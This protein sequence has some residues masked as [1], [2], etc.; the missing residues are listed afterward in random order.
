MT[1]KLAPVTDALVAR[2]EAAFPNISTVVGDRPQDLYPAHVVHQVDG[3]S[4]FFR[5]LDSTHGDGT[6][7]WQVTCVALNAAH[8][9]GMRDDVVAAL[10]TEPP[11]GV[12][13]VRCASP[14]GV[15]PDRDVTPPVWVATPLFHLT[16]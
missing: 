12:K 11:D 14:G 15:R 7:A 6:F 3:G 4:G 1:V 5:D 13:L 9:A 2:L 8:A 10:T 16:I